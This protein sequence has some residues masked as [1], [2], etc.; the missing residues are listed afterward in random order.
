MLSTSAM[1]RMEEEAIVRQWL[2]SGR[3]NEGERVRPITVGHVLFLHLR[4]LNRTAGGSSQG[5]DECIPNP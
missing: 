4:P 1:D 3:G 5:V 2:Q